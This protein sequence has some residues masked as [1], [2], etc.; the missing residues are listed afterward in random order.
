MDKYKVFQAQPKNQ[1]MGIPP[2]TEE[3]LDAVNELLAKLPSSG[4]EPIQVDSDRMQILA[5]KRTT[6]NE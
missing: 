3:R 1:K 4:W 2:S 5:K 6:L